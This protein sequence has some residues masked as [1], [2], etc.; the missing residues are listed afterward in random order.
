MIR[1]S[2]SQ[3]SVR[4]MIEKNELFYVYGFSEK[5]QIP[6]S[7]KLGCVT[8]TDLKENHDKFN[9]FETSFSNQTIY[10]IRL[11]DVYD[12]WESGYITELMNHEPSKKNR[13]IYEEY[14]VK[15]FNDND[16]TT[17]LI[18]N[19]LTE[20]HKIN[21]NGKRLH[22]V[23]IERYQSKT[24]AEKIGRSLKS[25]FGLDFRVINSPK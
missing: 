15:S 12:K 5:L 17:N 7:L 25:K 20:V 9:F 10:I 13:L 18:N 4:Q 3:K 1:M 16:D 22:A 6:H 8:M 21:S 24:E 14:E 2:N 19:F 11:K 23:R